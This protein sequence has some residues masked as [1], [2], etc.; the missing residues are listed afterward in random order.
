M[1]KSHKDLKLHPPETFVFKFLKCKFDHIA[2]CADAMWNSRTENDPLKEVKV[3]IGCWYDDLI[4]LS[5]HIALEEFLE[6]AEVY[7]V[8]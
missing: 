6:N 2:C 1:I 7:G 3:E 4:H 5:S 8:T